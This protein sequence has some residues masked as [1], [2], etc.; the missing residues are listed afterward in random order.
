MALTGLQIFKLLPKT[1]CGEC[2]VPTCM[3]FAM[4]LAAKNAD[5]AACPYASDEVKKI[6]GAASK[7]PVR[8]VKIGP[9][10]AEVAI[11]NETVMFRHEKTFVHPAAVAIAFSDDQDLKRDL[12]HRIAEVREY[13]LERAGE[14]QRIDLVLV[15]NASGDAEPFVE[16]ARAAAGGAGRGLIL[17]STD[18]EA[19]DAA[20]AALPGQRP[21]IHA[22]TAGNADVIAA[23]AKKHK[24]PVV[25][26]AST[27][28]DLARLTKRLNGLGIEDLVL[29]LPA[30]NPA[31]TLQYNTAIRKSALKGGVEALG[32][33]ILNFVTGG[34]LPPLVA[35]AAT[36]LTKYASILILDRMDSQALMPLFMLRQNIYT[37]PQKP[38]QVE[39]RVYPI[40]D[41]GPD[42][43]VVA[44]TNFSLTYFLVSGEIENSGVPAHLVIVE[45]EGMSVLTAWAAGKFN[46]A[47][48]A[49]AIKAAG[50]EAQVRTRRIL[51]PGYVA[52]ISGELEEALPGWE[53]VVGPGEVGD[54]AP[55]LKKQAGL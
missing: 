29:E 35:D 28:D 37:D 55:L 26:Q 33:P 5:L 50:L 39:P 14:T 23:L 20:L 2:G 34:D 15:D 47:K 19:L 24:A 6:V 53:V 11:G 18:P 13:K 3:A 4:K 45:T 10:D 41:A 46:G 25:A 49:G 30:A 40:G 21:L 22:A 32:Y 42:S 17:K 12:C 27:L 36:F 54:L 38:I 8:L 51:I 52:Q 1:N 7:P 43:P 31:A 16:I 9:P 48:I 44:T